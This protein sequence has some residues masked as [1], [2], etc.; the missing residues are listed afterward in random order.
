LLSPR[1]RT[2]CQP[3]AASPASGP[4]LEGFGEEVP[5]ETMPELERRKRKKRNG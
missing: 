3:V 1:R 2:G 4:V 5:D